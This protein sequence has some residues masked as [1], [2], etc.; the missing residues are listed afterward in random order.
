MS[1]AQRPRKHSDQSPLP[2][3]SISSTCLEP[4]NMETEE[5]KH[6]FNSDFTSSQVTDPQPF[7]Q[8]KLNGLVRDLNLS[9]ESS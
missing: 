6:E 2:L 1:S 8:S 9:K 3:P 5:E 4:D 7:Y